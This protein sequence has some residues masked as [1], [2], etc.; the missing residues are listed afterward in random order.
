MTHIHNNTVVNNIAA[1]K[2]LYDALINKCNLF[3]FNV[4]MENLLKGNRYLYKSKQEVINSTQ[5][6]FSLFDKTVK[7]LQW[8]KK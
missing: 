8:E 2:L 3:S 7:L 1:F 5:M 4:N 6:I